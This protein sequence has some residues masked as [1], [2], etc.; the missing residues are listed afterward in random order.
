ML[1]VTLVG[2]ETDEWCWA[3][4]AQMTVGYAGA[5]VR[6]C[7][8]AN[9]YFNRTDC[10]TAPNSR[11]CRR[12][13]WPEYGRLGFKAKTT[14]WYKY[15]SFD[16]IKAEIDAGRPINFAW[17]WTKDEEGGHMMVL[18]GYSEGLGLKMVQVHNP[19]PVRKGAIKW[20]AYDEFISS[21]TYKHFR[22]Y[23]EI[24]RASTP[25]ASGTTR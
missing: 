17:E 16:K 14:D 13:G 19:W 24:M 4:S 20:L 11:N 5:S 12:P 25:V 22:D 15:L 1:A 2:Q 21:D 18:S 7:E 10:C 23:Y 8:Q 9:A 3:A 6:Q